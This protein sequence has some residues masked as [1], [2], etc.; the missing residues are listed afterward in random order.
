MKQE[1]LFQILVEKITALK[2]VK[3]NQ[4]DMFFS[5][6]RQRKTGDPHFL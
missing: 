5:S 4:G 6:C 2:E 1:I 3:V